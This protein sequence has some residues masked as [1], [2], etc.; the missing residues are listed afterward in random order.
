MLKLSAN[1]EAPYTFVL[2]MT[3]TLRGSDVDVNL[4]GTFHDVTLRENA[5]A[6]VKESADFTEAINNATPNILYVFDLQKFSNVYTNKHIEEILGYSKD[7]VQSMGASFLPTI[8]HKEDKHLLDEHFSKVFI[9]KD[10][11][12][13]S[14]E[15][16]VKHKNGDYIWLISRDV[17]FKRNQDGKPRQTLG[18]AYDISARKES[19]FQ[20][21][22]QNF[23]IQSILQSSKTRICSVNLDRQIVFHNRLFVE[24]INTIN[25]DKSTKKQLETTDW[26]SKELAEIFRSEDISAKFY[27]G[28]DRSRVVGEVAFQEKVI[29]SKGELTYQ[30]KINP[31]YN[32]EEGGNGALEG[33]SI[34]ITDITELV[35]NQKALIKATEQA[36]A[37]NKAKSVFL[38]NMSHEIRTPL[39][40]I[41]GFAELMKN[42]A[43]KPE[44][45][46]YA[47]TIVG[48]GKA[49][50]NI[51]NDILDL[52][53][54]EAGKIE[55]R[56]EDVSL[57]QVADEVVTLYQ[58]RAEKKGLKLIFD[59]RIEKSYDYYLDGQKVAQILNNL[60]SNAI[61][62]TD[63]G[64]I[65]IVAEM[66]EHES[67]G[68][69]TY[70]DLILSVADKGIGIPESQ[71]Q[72]IFQPFIQQD[73]QDSR[74][75]GGTGLGL[76]IIKN[77]SEM[78]NGELSLESEHGKG[79]TF[80]VHFHNVR[81][82]KRKDEAQEKVELEAYGAL[83]LS[84]DDSDMNQK[85]IQGILKKT[86]HHIHYAMNAHQ[87][88]D[89][90][91]NNNP[92][93]IIMDIHMPEVD[94]VELT[95]NIRSQEQFSDIAIIAATGYVFDEDDKS[96]EL[97]SDIIY[98]PINSKA[99]LNAVDKYVTSKTKVINTNTDSNV[100]K[101]ESHSPAI[102]KAEVT[103]AEWKRFGPQVNKLAFTMEMDAIDNLAK[104]MADY[105]SGLPQDKAKQKE[106]VAYFVEESNILINAISEFDIDMITVTLNKLK[107]KFNTYNEN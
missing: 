19:E 60:V 14:V 41:L 54:I 85:I 1:G 53:K 78:M 8:V 52:S 3:F 100:T 29:D 96:K 66:L 51:I 2:D 43:I 83:I 47:Q 6:K 13:L 42:E 103:E 22:D 59:D 10:Q 24:F 5:I 26:E 95:K 94:G 30:I 4:L 16:R 32:R 84:V 87:A 35:L 71:Q 75:Y 79:S 63:E 101:T 68:E 107:E 76:S 48:S 62:F 58:Y 106:R 40:A 36:E 7:E 17:V 11:E 57:R 34:F 104:E 70:C 67:L 37:A 102:V 33:H 98:K 12:V 73:E 28:I 20:I 82:R 49:L 61:K 81:Y 90:L 88:M 74:K 50:L 46:N 97:F 105:Y 44:V 18:V 77:L 72:R 92:D 27:E 15:Y 93:L 23:K 25:G 38:A 21:K 64:E 56:Y 80:R 69:E 39:N 55:L 9:A 91:E 31:I 89:F 45:K 86:P 65:Y 99:L